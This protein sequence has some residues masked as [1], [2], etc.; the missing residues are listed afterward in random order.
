M[1]EVLVEA[2]PVAETGKE[3]VKEEV[4]YEGEMSYL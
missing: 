4:D 3:T 1:D 2:P